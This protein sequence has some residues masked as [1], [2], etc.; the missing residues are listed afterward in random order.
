M[1]SCLSAAGDTDTRALEEKCQ[2]VT[3]TAFNLKVYVCFLLHRMYIVENR[4]T[5]LLT[6]NIY[7]CDSDIR[8]WPDSFMDIIG[9]WNGGGTSVCVGCSAWCHLSLVLRKPCICE[10]MILVHMN[11]WL[12][13]W[14]PCRVFLWVYLM[15]QVFTVVNIKVAVMWNVVLC[16]LMETDCHCRDDYCLH[17]WGD[18]NWG[19]K[20]LQYVGQ[21]PWDYTMQHHR[22]QSSSDIFVSFTWMG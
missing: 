10:C 21:F 7:Y 8:M 11:V 13:M 1:W 15:F 5:V 17:P 9:S 16:S 18:D 19:S 4:H 12:H 6:V 20:H 2:I 22:R 3:L 14:S